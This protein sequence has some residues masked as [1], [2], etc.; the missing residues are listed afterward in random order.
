MPASMILILLCAELCYLVLERRQAREDRAKLTH[1]IH[2]NGIRGKST[3]TRLI[4]AGL[5]AGGIA[6]YCKTTGTLPMTVD[7]RGEERPIRRLGPANIREQ[8]R[9]MHKAA[10]QG[11]QVLVAECMAVDP[12]LQKIAQRKMLRADIGVI[13][14][15]RLDHTDEMGATLPQIC[16]SLCNMLPENGVVFTADP[17]FAGQIG[18]R[19][20][21]LGSRCVLTSPEGLPPQE[22]DFDENVAL[23]LA[24]CQHLGVERDTALAGMARYH[25]DPYALSLHKLPG[26]A[27][28]IGAL[29]AND[30][31]STCG[32][33]NLLRDKHGLEEKR[34]VLL[35]NNRRDRGYRTEHMLLV[36]RALKPDE[37]W[38]MGASRQALSR[39]LRQQGND[40]IRSFARVEE[41]PLAQAGKETVIF[42]AGNLAGQGR[43]LMELV[44]KE[45]E[46]LVP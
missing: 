15:V 18:K 11:A 37:I 42:A 45:G 19:A 39:R 43:P 14:N 9:T 36:A 12:E 41:L 32:I 22:I 44:E 27:R 4:A 5:Q 25:R 21:E 6:A 16:D 8:L 17:T 40:N 28:F 29:S 1:V 46:R 24:V 10:D 23:A 26:G 38:L 31:Q 34:L 7:T 2:V 35:L 30:P 13:T 3:V 33:W 20:E